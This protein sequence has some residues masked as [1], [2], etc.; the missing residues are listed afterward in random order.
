MPFVSIIILNYNKKDLLLKCVQS[1]LDLTKYPSYEI[2]V[3]DNG[4]IDGSVKEIK[5]VF[6]DTVKLKVVAL[7][8]NLGYAEGNNIGYL[9]VSKASK[10]VVILNNDVTIDREN[11]LRT[12]VDYLEKY[13]DVGVAQPLI[14]DS[15]NDQA[16]ISGFNMNVFGEFF[17]I[18]ILDQ[19]DMNTRGDFTECFSVLGAAFI[20]RKE[21]IE[22]IGLFNCRFFLNYEDADFCWRLRLFGSNVVVFPSS[23]VR[24]MNGATINSFYLTSPILQFHIL[25]NRIYMLFVNYELSN[26][27]LYAPWVVLSEVYDAI[28]CIIFSMFEKGIPKKIVNSRGLAA[29]KS[30]AYFLVHFRDI[31]KDRLN[32][33]CNIRTIPDSE[34]IGKYILRARPLLARRTK[35]AGTI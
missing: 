18:K 8:Q 19:P 12:L 20:T 15:N 28:N 4:S 25:K 16:K 2:V 33:Q 32:V 10:Y 27:A 14:V 26:V 9:N 11:W 6:G 35:P 24:H 23:R 7:S 17:G 31:W 13:K 21:L 30:F 3:T 5:K 29:P 22:K 34:L 1:V